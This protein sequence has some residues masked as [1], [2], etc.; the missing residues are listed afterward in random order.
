M[1]ALIIYNI[2][3][4]ICPIKLKQR[5]LYGLFQHFCLYPSILIILIAD[6][7]Q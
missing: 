2:L 3:G 6:I 1:I 5:D 4:T 7:F